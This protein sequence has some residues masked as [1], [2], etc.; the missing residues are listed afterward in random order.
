MLLMNKDKAEKYFRESE[1]WWKKYGIVESHRHP[2]SGQ[3]IRGVR[4]KLGDKTQA[5]DVYDSTSGRWE[6]VPIAGVILTE[7]TGAI[8]VRPT[9]K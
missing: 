9:P 2:V 8:L 4:L 7:D 6:K 3:I 5:S 1:W